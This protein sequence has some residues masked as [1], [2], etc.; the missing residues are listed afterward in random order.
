MNN[1]VNI[2]KVLP[3]SYKAMRTFAQSTR[4][5]S[6]NPL[7]I[8]LI[9]I[10]TSQINGCAFCLDMHARDA[11]KLGESE[12]RIYML[13]AW[14]ETNFYSEEEKAI[15]ALTEEL[16]LIHGNIKDET[17]DNAVKVLTEIQIAEVVM[18]AVVINSWNR[19]SKTSLTQPPTL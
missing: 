19:I 5:S 14:R 11:R 4:A 16:A 18:T 8:E 7:Q 15:L 6:L 9:K 10:R 12:R 13:S 17:Y 2:E 3:E 1:R